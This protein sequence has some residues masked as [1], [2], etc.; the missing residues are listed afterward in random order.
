MAMVQTNVRVPAEAKAHVL[1]LARRLR[2]DEGATDRLRA[3]LGGRDD[4]LAARVKRLETI[5][6][7]GGQN[8]PAAV[9][10]KPSPATGKD[11]PMSFESALQ[12]YGPAR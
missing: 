4:D 5:L 7:G 10:P 12:Q 1:E 3:F 8:H 9:A 11:R 6:I 2:A